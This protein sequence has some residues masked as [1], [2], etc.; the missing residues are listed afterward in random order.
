MVFLLINQLIF[1]QAIVFWTILIFRWNICT[2]LPVQRH[3]TT[4]CYFH[5]VF[6]HLS[7][8]NWF[9]FN[10]FNSAWSLIIFF[11]VFRLIS[12]WK[13]CF[14]CIK[15]MAGSTFTSKAL[16][17][18]VATPF[19][20]FFIK[21][22]DAVLATIVQP[23]KYCADGGESK[24]ESRKVSWPVFWI[25]LIYMQTFRV[26]YSTV[27]NRIESKDIVSTLQRWR[28][29]LRAVRFRGLRKRR[30]SKFGKEK[31]DG[32]GGKDI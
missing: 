8:F 4:L 27:F 31:S 3:F 10:F 1:C 22:I 9:F 16:E 29:M 11:F 15:E 7:I 5:S 25:V 14:F 18:V 2:T 17:T 23:A 20:Q 13:F 30:E 19:G 12:I 28:R 6:E 32:N 26:V 24:G 21:K